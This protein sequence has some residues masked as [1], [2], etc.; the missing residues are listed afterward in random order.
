MN[1]LRPSL[2]ALA[3]ASAMPALAQTPSTWTA[4]A[5]TTGVWRDH[6][7]I[8]GGHEDVRSDYLGVRAGLSTAWSPRL[9]GGVSVNADTL[10]YD[11][12]SAPAPWKRVERYGLS[13]PLSYSLAGGWMLAA[14]P[15]LD[16]M[17]EKGASSSDSLVWGSTLAVIKGF[18]ADRSFGLGA[19][20]YRRFDDTVVFPLLIVDWNLGGAWSIAN[21]LAAGPTGPAGL[22]LRYQIAPQWQAGAGAAWRSIAFRLDD[23]RP[24]VAIDSGV[25][26]FAR[27]S[28]SP[29]ADL[30]LDFVAGVVTLGRLQIETPSGSQIDKRHLGNSALV[31]LSLRGRF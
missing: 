14:T 5:S 19:A 10:R 11:F 20:V 31:G 2:I 8:E 12:S 1:L 4:N 26:V 17:R 3:L 23:A 28:Y 21:P 6:S 18:A 25:P 13:A 9:R 16:V 24:A 27:L 7:S 29:S 30:S 15:S 22:E